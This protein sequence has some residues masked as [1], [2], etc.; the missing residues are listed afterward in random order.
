KGIDSSKDMIRVAKKYAPDG[1]FKVGDA[2]DLSSEKMYDTV[3]ATSLLIHIERKDLQ[4][5]IEQMW[6]HTRK[7]LVF[8]IPIDK[9]FSKV[10]ELS[11]KISEAS[12]TTLITHVSHKTLEGL[13]NNLK[14]KRIEKK[15]FPKGCFGYGLNDYLIKTVKAKNNV[16]EE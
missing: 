2:Y 15:P 14:P 16:V 4:H 1:S 7:A 3:I 10:F 9:D 11:S 13:L 8:T 5:I 12:E 6:T